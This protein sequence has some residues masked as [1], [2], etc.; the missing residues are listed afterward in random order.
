MGHLRQHAARRRPQRRMVVTA[1]RRDDDDRV[2][3]PGRTVT[4]DGL[5][6]SPAERGL[7]VVE[8][9]QRPSDPAQPA[10]TE[11]GRLEIGAQCRDQMALGDGPGIGA[12][13]P[14]ELQN[15]QIQTR[16]RR[17][18]RRLG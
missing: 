14:A 8:Q 16:V 15:E 10:H 1:Q 17:F 6:Q 9:D 2:V 13:T 12:G 4:Q 7:C 18:R 11:I 3:P 5:Q